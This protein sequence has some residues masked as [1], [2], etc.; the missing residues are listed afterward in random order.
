MDRGDEERAME[1]VKKSVA[2]LA[3]ISLDDD[4]ILTEMWQSGEW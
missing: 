2:I 3:E 4:E 1:L